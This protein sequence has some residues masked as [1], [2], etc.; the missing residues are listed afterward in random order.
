MN[1]KIYSFW[2]AV[3]TQNEKQL[4][5]Y[6]DPKATIYWQDSN[7]QFSVEHFII[8][9]C[10]YPGVWQ[11]QINKL[12]KIQENQYMTVTY[13]EETNEHFSSYAISF[14]EFKD[15][16]ICRLEEYWTENSDPPEWRK[17]LKIGKPIND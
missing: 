17:K 7:E 3:A 15:E 16:K 12:I 14:F 13:V 5:T 11:A 8:A 1:Q 10:K 6:F 4:R 9:N 2:E